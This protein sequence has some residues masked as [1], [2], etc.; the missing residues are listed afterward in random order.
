[1]QTRTLLTATLAATVLAT[2]C[3]SPKTPAET[4][5]SPDTWAVVDGQPITKDATEKAFRR[6][7]NPNETL[8][9]RRRTSRRSSRCSTT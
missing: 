9:R 7:R 8:V 1:M 3:N 4:A 6:L 2:A 5:P